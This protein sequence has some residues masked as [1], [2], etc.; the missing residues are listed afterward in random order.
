M[1]LARL[2]VKSPPLPW[3][4]WLTCPSPHRQCSPSIMLRAHKHW[5][6]VILW[7]GFIF[8]MSTELGSFAH[9]SRIIEPLLR[10]LYPGI[11]AKTVDLVHLLIRKGGH[12][13]EYAVL[14]LL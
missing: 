9:T 10:W 2:A 3:L 11:S 6:P 4:E 12:L 14:A 8:V 1:E 13:T 5:L 7:M